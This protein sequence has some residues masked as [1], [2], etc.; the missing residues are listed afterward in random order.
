LLDR[1]S[2]R[3]AS[4]FEGQGGAM[5]PAA[6]A[7]AGST[8]SATKTNHTS[9][10]LRLRRAVDAARKGSTRSAA[11]DGAEGATGR[12]AASTAVAKWQRGAEAA[13]AAG[14]S[15]G[16]VPAKKYGQSAWDMAGK[17]HDLNELRERRNAA[18]TKGLRKMYK[19]FKQKDFAPLYDI[20]DDAPSIFFECWYTSANSSIRM[21]S[22]AMC[23]K[24][25]PMYEARLLEECG[26]EPPPPTALE[27]AAIAARG[28]PL[29]IS[30]S[31]NHDPPTAGKLRDAAGAIHA[32]SAFASAMKRGNRLRI[33]QV[34]ADAKSQEVGDN[35]GDGGKA[36]GNAS[37]KPSS[38]PSSKAPSRASSAGARP[39]S[40]APASSSLTSLI[41]EQLAASKQK[42]S[43]AGPSRGEAVVVDDWR[44]EGGAESAD[45]DPLVDV[46]DEEHAADSEAAVDDVGDDD[47][48]ASARKRA[49]AARKQFARRKAA[50]AAAEAEA[51]CAADELDQELDGGAAKGASTGKKPKKGG[52]KK[53]R[54][55]DASRKNRPDRD[56]FFA[57]MFTA[58]CKH[59]MG[60]ET[61]PLLER[62]DVAW[63]THDFWDT[64][65]LFGY[66]KESLHAVSIDD[67]L[68]LLMRIMIMEYNQILFERRYRLK[69]G[70]REALTTLRA[71][72]LT[73]P[74][75][76]NDPIQ[77][78]NEFHHSFYLATHIVYVQSAYN[79]IKADQ[80]EIPWLYRYVRQS[81][82]FWMRQVKLQR[83]DPDVYVDIDGIGEIC[84]C[85]RGCG[86]TEGNDAM[87]C[88]GTLYMLRT[89]RKN[90][91]WPS[92]LPGDDTPEK[93]LDYYHR[94]HPTWVCTQALRDRDFKIGN[95]A[96]WPEFIG[97][98]LKETKFDTLA[99]KP[100]W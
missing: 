80:R 96:F 71:T 54:S 46:D 41:S 18:V 63:K 82:R 4:V 57:L 30:S 67:W 79:A 38:K 35:T 78:T 83:K 51:L 75:R 33:T 26:Y 73:P 1:D 39:P 56:D 21:E 12:A 23:K 91:M 76:P 74:P 50:E 100:G 61:E 59:E 48:D 28:K 69:W 53:P 3:L 70:L 34:I 97:K 60:E 11:G 13:A 52:G 94:I 58:R 64:D 86:M 6:A 15:E 10:S 85:L 37:S 32:A 7:D 47:E 17:E 45:S 14:S 31:G 29:G 2:Q 19:F 93:D 44:P 5:A 9:S 62:A 43:V 99:Y 89:Q 77:F 66:K 22:K 68:M 25:L 95:N 84:D 16:A 87:L 65:K 49:A 20:G 72:P 36:R 42:G 92:V 55:V 27:L 24:L 90:G 98:V 88:E 81:M 40:A 8:S